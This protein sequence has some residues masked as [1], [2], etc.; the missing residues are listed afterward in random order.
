MEMH[1]IEIQSKRRAKDIIWERLCKE[2]PLVLVVVLD[3][4]YL[5]ASA[6][7][8]NQAVPTLLDW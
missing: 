8:Q 6:M 4:P 7:Q 5:S 1:K 2:E 3:L